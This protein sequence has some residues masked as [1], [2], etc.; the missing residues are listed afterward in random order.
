MALAKIENGGKQVFVI[1]TIPR[2]CRGFSKISTLSVECNDIKA[3]EYCTCT[4]HWEV[5][6]MYFCFCHLYQKIIMPRVEGRI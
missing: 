1:R 4:Q 6:P 2:V 5:A 3:G